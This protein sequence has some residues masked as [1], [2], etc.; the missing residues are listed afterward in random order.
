MEDRVDIKLAFTTLACFA[1]ISFLLSSQYIKQRRRKLALSSCYL[2]TEIKPQDT[3]KRV[4]AD[5]SYSP[6]KHLKLNDLNNETASDCH[7]YGEEIAALLEK[8]NMEFSFVK[9]NGNYKTGNPYVWVDTEAQ[10]RDLADELSK[11]RVF[12]VDTEQHSIRSFLGFTALI[13]ISTEKE[14]YLVDT[15]ALHDEMGILRP[16]FANPHIC[17]VFHGADNDVLWLQRDFHVYVVNLFDT[18]KACEVLSKPQ[19]SLAYLLE[20]YCG[21]ATNKLLQREDWRQRPLS[22]EM[23]EYA[24]TDAHFLLYIA[25]SL[26][27]ELKEQVVEDSASLDDNFHFVLEA[28]RRSNTTCLQLY[29][30]ELEAF[31]GESAA[32]SILSRQLNG[33]PGISE[34]A[35]E[36]FQDIV[37]K[38]CSWRDLMA[39]VHDESLKY[40]LSDQAI[41]ALAS[42]VP[43][44]E[45]EIYEVLSQADLHTDSL[46]FSSFPSPSP[47]VSSH[48]DDLYCLFQDNINNSEDIFLKILQKHLGTN[49]SCP[50]S[51]YNYSL[52]AKSKIKATNGSV[53]KQN[54]LKNVR[55]AGRKA[56]RELF[57]QKFSCKSP[58]YHNCRIYASDGRLLCYCDRRK[59]EWYLRRDLAKLVEENPP[60]IMLLFEPKGRPEDE[61]NDFYIQSKKNICVG[62]GERSHYLRYRIIPS[63]YRI[64]FPE[65]LK[66][67]R[68]HDIVLLCVD[69]H[70][71]A[72]ASAEKHKRQIAAEFGIPL[73]VQKVVDPKESELVFDSTMNLED[74]GVSPLQLRTAAMA[75]LRHGPRMPPKRREELIQIVMKYYGGREISQKDLERAL[76]VGMS[77]HERRKLEKKKGLSFRHSTGCALDSKGGNSDKNRVSETREISVLDTDVNGESISLSNGTVDSYCL[78]S[79]QTLGPGHNSKL[80]LLGH[81]PHGKRVVDYLL[82]EHRE[83]GIRQFCQR[84]RQVFVE[85][86]RP[87]FL[88]AGWDVMHSGRRD[89]GEYSV[90]NPAKRASEM[91]AAL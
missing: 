36:K 43:S 7:P 67:H 58:V 40:V 70:E 10:L 12:A 5:N 83:D 84:W 75:L 3:F 65:H 46:S 77:P 30:K 8:P 27:A 9:E 88:P 19:K 49:G 66:S 64:H 54:A 53:F 42:K 38:L 78:G 74:S 68:S 50:L 14:D 18:S 24:Q 81:G 91:D 17:K 4:L 15:I 71:I 69:C 2:K 6:F 31:P 52:L 80:S 1:A 20:A 47:V 44:L 26:I 56:S 37:R 33:Q 25:D 41:I 82:R 23:V 21:V 16:A 76:L 60:A 63:C 72:H 22:E 86:I 90:Y 13:Q 48:I 32:S 89:F 51:V 11:V 45:T 85:S 87:R 55:L 29:S 61:D 57:V 59:L 73:F 62:C 35:S 34:T 79:E 39:R 28:S